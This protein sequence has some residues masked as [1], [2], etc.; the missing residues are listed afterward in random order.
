[1]LRVGVCQGRGFRPFRPGIMRRRDELDLL[2]ASQENVLQSNNEKLIEQAS[3]YL[4]EIGLNDSESWNTSV[5][6]R[7]SAGGTGETTSAARR[8]SLNAISE[9]GSDYFTD[10][11]SLVAMARRMNAAGDLDSVVSGDATICMD[12]RFGHDAIGTRARSSLPSISEIK[13]LAKIL[14]PS[15][16]PP[17]KYRPAPSPSS[18]H[19]RGE[20][21]RSVPWEGESGAPENLSCIRAETS[22]ANVKRESVGRRSSNGSALSLERAHWDAEEIRRY[23]NRS[24]KGGTSASP[25][26]NI[27]RKLHERNLGSNPESEVERRRGSIK[28]KKTH[29]LRNRKGKSV[30]SDDDEPMQ[31]IGF[32]TRLPDGKRG[33]EWPGTQAKPRP[34]SRSQCR[35]GEDRS[36]NDRRSL[37]IPKRVDRTRQEDPPPAFPTQMR[38]NAD[39]NSVY[40]SDDQT[41]FFY[42]STDDEFDSDDEPTLSVSEA[43]AEMNRNKLKGLF[44]R[45]K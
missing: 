4:N 32:N 33:G 37:S 45:F 30:D 6:T 40:D 43:V 26:R 19:Q 39:D 36:K 27:P 14:E 42:E 38:G 34:R 22:R 44:G 9:D 18:S 5:P 31:G 21:N 41:Q 17:P 2:S 7:K 12:N 20:K 16:P 28:G 15:A 13:K 11:D 29:K 25:P 3:Q 1:M 10:D 24:R 35:N 23:R 8:K